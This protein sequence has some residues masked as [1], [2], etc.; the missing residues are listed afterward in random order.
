[1]RVLWEKK[2]HSL[3]RSMRWFYSFFGV[4]SSED[5]YLARCFNR[6][7]LGGELCNLQSLGGGDGCWWA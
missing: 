5:V 1:M 4:R 6:V 3:S 7:S 2:G